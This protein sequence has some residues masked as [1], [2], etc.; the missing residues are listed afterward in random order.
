[1]TKNERIAQ[2]EAE[3]EA[4]K[5]RIVL[6]E[7]RPIAPLYVPTE[8]TQPWYRPIVD[9]YCTCGTSA[10]CPIHGIVWSYTVAPADILPGT[11]SEVVYPGRRTNIRWC[12]WDGSTL[13]ADGHV[14]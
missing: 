1:M 6:L 10:V 12:S 5:L 8:P 7:A 3:V 11:A 2:L 4:L 9:N 13:D 14:Q